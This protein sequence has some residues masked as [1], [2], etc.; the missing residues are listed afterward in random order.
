MGLLN[1]AQVLCNSE[2]K[3]RLSST[4]IS[5][6]NLYMNSSTNGSVLLIELI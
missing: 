5:S 2:A 3:L 1:Y 4:S 6:D